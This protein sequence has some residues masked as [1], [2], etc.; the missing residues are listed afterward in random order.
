MHFRACCWFTLLAVTSALLVSCGP[1]EVKGPGNRKEL[2]K[3]T[4]TVQVN[5]AP[6][7]EIKIIA[8]PAVEDPGNPHSGQAR[9]AEDGTFQFSTYVTNDG[10][11]AGDYILQV[12]WPEFSPLHRSFVGDKFGGKYD[13]I[14]EN[15][16]MEKP[17]LTF[18]VTAGQP[19]A[20]E[21]PLDLP[22]GEEAK[23]KGLGGVGKP[24]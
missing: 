19:L 1:G 8:M 6:Q 9:S 12:T 20:L 22:T 2:T 3:V 11:P 15:K 14:E 7:G 5:G 13:K 23:K 17:K 18:T 16:K 21:I 24:E 10:L 4:G